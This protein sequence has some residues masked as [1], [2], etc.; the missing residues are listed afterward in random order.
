MTIAN[1]LFVKC[2]DVVALQTRADTAAIAG[3]VTEAYT[4]FA[5]ALPAKVVEVGSQDVSGEQVEEGV[6]HIVTISERS[7]AEN[8]EYVLCTARAG[9][10]VSEQYRVQRMRLVGPP[11]A[12][13]RM[14]LCE[15]I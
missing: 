6:T 15:K 3:G 12:R 10:V 5:T 7:G 8:A 13:F 11:N 2:G 4:S 14:L 9:T 1:R